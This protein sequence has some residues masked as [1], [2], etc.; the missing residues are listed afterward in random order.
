MDGPGIMLSSSRMNA[1]GLRDRTGSQGISHLLMHREVVAVPAERGLPAGFWNAYS[2]LAN[3]LG[4]VIVLGVQEDKAAGTLAPTGLQ[5][6]EKVLEEIYEGLERENKVSANILFDS[7]IH[8]MEYEGAPVLLVDVPKAGRKV[9]PV[10]VGFDLYGGCYR[11]DRGRERLCTREEIQTM[12]REREDGADG[13]VLTDLALTALDGESLKLYRLIF[14]AKR[15]R[16]PWND[17]QDEEFLVR[18][19]AAARGAKWQMHPTVAGLL[20]F[21]ER[22]ALR[23]AFPKYVLDYRE[24]LPGGSWL[25]RVSSRDPDWSGNV[26]DFY[27]RAIDSLAAAAPIPDWKDGARIRV[28]R[29]EIGSGIGEVFANALIHADYYGGGGIVADQAKDLLRVANPGTFQVDAAEALSGGV[30]SRRNENLAGLFRFIGIGTGSGEG[31]SR[32]RKTWE[33]YGLPIPQVMEHMVMNRVT[34]TLYMETKKEADPTPAFGK[35][36]EK[37][38]RRKEEKSAGPQ[39]APVAIPPLEETVV[40]V[41]DNGQ[42]DGSGGVL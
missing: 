11:R 4:G 16:H 30:V 10:R 42:D 32:V 25:N 28:F 19:G 21:G 6:P 35:L 34:V 18:T 40:M 39:K 33:R 29:S 38:A 27:C 2:A 36:V 12:I 37:E 20:F 26:F 24:I 5:E 3:S 17:L 9:R 31:L 8:R 14:S 1:A 7:R 41:R 23:A 13:K 22:E 15:P